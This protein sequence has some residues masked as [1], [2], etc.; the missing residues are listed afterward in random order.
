[1][2]RIDKK[3]TDIHISTRKSIYLKYMHISGKDMNSTWIRKEEKIMPLITCNIIFYRKH[4]KDSFLEL[5]AF[6][7]ENETTTLKGYVHPQGHDCIIYSPQD[8]KA[9]S[10]SIDIED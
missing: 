5:L 8:M 9:T 2:S 7:K 6:S 3:D 4:P 1:M 10:V